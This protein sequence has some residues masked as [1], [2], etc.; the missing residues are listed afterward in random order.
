MTN[1]STI[2]EPLLCRCCGQ[3]VHTFEQILKHPRFEGGEKR[4]PLAEC[5]N[6]DCKL[7]MQTREPVELATMDLSIYGVEAVS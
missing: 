3:A 5:H 6:R 2:T 7:W 1:D 4:Y